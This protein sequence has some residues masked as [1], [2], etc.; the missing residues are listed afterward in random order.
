MRI[1]SSII[2][3]LTILSF[4][5]VSG[6]LIFY[7]T[8]DNDF[9]SLISTFLFKIAFLFFMS[10]VF[11]A[12]IDPR[13]PIFM[14]AM[15]DAVFY[16]ITYFLLFIFF[17]DSSIMSSPFYQTKNLIFPN[18]VNTIGWISFVI[19]YFLRLAYGNS[20]PPFIGKD[21][22][23]RFQRSL[24]L[25]NQNFFQ[26]YKKV[27]A[28]IIGWM[29]LSLILN[30]TIFLSRGTLRGTGNIPESVAFLVNLAG[31][32]DIFIIGL[33]TLVAARMN[34]KGSVSHIRSMLLLAFALLFLT[35]IKLLTSTAKETIVIPSLIAI[36]VWYLRTGKFPI[37][38]LSF[39]LIFYIVFAPINAYL[40]NDAEI[41]SN[42]SIQFYDYIRIS[43]LVIEQMLTNREFLTDTV[44]GTLARIDLVG[45]SAALIN[46]VEAGLIPT[47]NGSSF[48]IFFYSFIPRLIIPFKPVNSDLYDA[49]YL[50]RATG[51]IPFDNTSTAIAFGASAE[52]YLNL[53]IPAVV[54]GM[55]V[56]GF[57][58]KS[59]YDLIFQRPEF[60][61]LSILAMSFP[62]YAVFSA[63]TSSFSSL[64]GT[65]PIAIVSIFIVFLVSYLVPTWDYEQSN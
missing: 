56:L 50:G 28:F 26:N 16:G 22:F 21:V 36:L 65:I 30:L 53:K 3:N 24:A 61:D 31:N 13:E 35:G 12:K 19:G 43:L 2:L 17:K 18:I 44:V 8:Q 49:A 29:G 37:K 42:Q 39:G 25:D 46:K 9:Y 10:L 52:L 57:L 60:S 11:N 14:L 6:L 51:I 27:E 33:S 58:L 62:L 55:M 4:I 23:K 34:T 1:K 45:A 64:A 15:V 5:F 7:T 41:V 38:L 48:L 47:S 40:R 63:Y 54:L 59:F 32:F 20:F